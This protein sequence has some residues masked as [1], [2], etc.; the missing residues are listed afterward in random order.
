MA[1]GAAATTASCA[2]DLRE[3][4]VAIYRSQVPTRPTMFLV[5]GPDGRMAT[6]MATSSRAA[7]DQY[8]ASKRTKPGDLISVKQRGANEWRDYQVR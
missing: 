1:V 8:V 5:R 6:V 7:C 4:V 2:G 3:R